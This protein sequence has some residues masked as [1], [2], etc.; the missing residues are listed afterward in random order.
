MT[1]QSDN[2][3]E[4]IRELARMGAEHQ[5]HHPDMTVLADFL[6]GFLSEGDKEHVRNHLA[7][8]PSCTDRLQE[9]DGTDLQP[10]DVD[11]EMAPVPL[12]KPEPLVHAE[13]PRRLWHSPVVAWAHAAIFLIGLLIVSRQAW[14]QKHR[15]EE[16]KAPT[17]TRLLELSPSGES[18]E[19][20][21]IPHAAAEGAAGQK[22][23]IFLDTAGLPEGPFYMR[24]HHQETVIWTEYPVTPTSDGFLYLFV[25]DSLA[26]GCYSIELQNENRE[27]KAI[28]HWCLD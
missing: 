19:K 27:I 5:E 24:L 2:L 26:P 16:L 20:S 18:H 15:I 14:K 6:D 7:L 11:L 10:D 8:C 22:I 4:S 28:Y 17:L 25:P 9:L 21:A 13:R 12:E 1:H 23:S 3:D